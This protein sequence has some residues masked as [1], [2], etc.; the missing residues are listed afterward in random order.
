MNRKI[1]G[2]RKKEKSENK[3]ECET[4]IREDDDRR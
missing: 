4:E 2:E 1:K 3:Q